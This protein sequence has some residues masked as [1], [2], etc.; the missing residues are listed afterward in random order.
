[1]TG[2]VGGRETSSNPESILTELCRLKRSPGSTAPSRVTA[3][4]GS[5]E[6]VEVLKSKGGRDVGCCGSGTE[7]FGARGL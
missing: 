2:R 1:V 3:E 7:I 6:A 5:S 4:K